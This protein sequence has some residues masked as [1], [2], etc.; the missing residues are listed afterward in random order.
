MGRTR[1]TVLAGSVT[2]LGIVGAVSLLSLG[3]DPYQ[4]RRG[5]RM[6]T[7]EPLLAETGVAP[8]QGYPHAYHGLVTD[9]TEASQ[10]R[11]EYF[12]E[13]SP[14]SAQKFADVSFEDGFLIVLGLVLPEEKTLRSV[15]TQFEDG[16]MV[17]EYAVVDRSSAATGLRVASVVEYWE[18]DRRN[19][20]PT[21]LTVAFRYAE[22]EP[23]N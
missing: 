15:G 17:T 18:Y 2:T 9:Q 22:S 4:F 13:A 11:W 5:G 21:E 7:D 19:T 6:G 10:I 16:T 12:Q 20:P 8:E 1:R 14:A 3:A 23:T